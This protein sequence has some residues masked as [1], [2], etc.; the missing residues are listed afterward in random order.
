MPFKEGNR[1]YWMEVGNNSCQWESYDE[2]K[3]FHTCGQKADHVH[4]IQP[5]HYL[6]GQGVDPEQSVGM[7]LC[8]RHHMRNTGGEIFDN[9]S[10]MHPDYG[11]AY[12]HYREWKSNEEHMMSITGRRVVDYSTSPFADVGREHRIKSERGE[13]YHTGTDDT[14][15]YY[16]DKMRNMATKFNAEN[17]RSKPQLKQHKEH[18]PTK[19][20]KWWDGLF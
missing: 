6:L 20:K 18:D 13:R 15:E 7:P 17:D 12:T 9:D 10:S 1:K 19:K 4:H 2:K 16:I 3:G 11:E 5:E 8:A 14:D